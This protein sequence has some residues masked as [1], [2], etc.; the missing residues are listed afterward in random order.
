[1][2]KTADMSVAEFADQT[3][4]ALTGQTTSQDNFVYQAKPRGSNLQVGRDL[5]YS[6]VF[7]N[8]FFSYAC[9]VDVLL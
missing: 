8:L 9:S 5:K 2:A 3:G 4:R 1:M 7:V 6:T